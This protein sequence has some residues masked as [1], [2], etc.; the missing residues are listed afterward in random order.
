MKKVWFFLIAVTGLLLSVGLFGGQLSS[1]RP[2]IEPAPTAKKI[3]VI[4]TFYPL[5]E[6]TQQV[7]GDL[8]EVTNLTPAGVEPHDFEPSP[9]DIVALHQA[10][11]IIY[12]GAGFESWLEF[13][14]SD[15]PAARL[16]DTSESIALMG[17]DPHLWLD[18]A[19]AADQVKRITSALIELDPEHRSDYQSRAAAYLQQLTELDTLFQTTL[20]NCQTRKMVTSHN[21]FG[22]LARAYN[23]QVESIASF[24]PDE[25]PSAQELAALTEFVKKNQVKYVFSEILISPKLS[26]TLA[27]ETGAQIL[28]FNPLEGLT[29]AE[30]A[31]GKNYLSIQRENVAALKTA[32]QCQ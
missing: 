22:Y 21:S 2:V 24:S 6:F 25:E 12:N 13:L 9:Q 19:L 29:P 18:P 3:K 8:V 17:N 30:L 23:L 11:L 7:G 27:A 20:R 28:V 16:V 15:L 5:A 4:A 10:D 1:N 14:K 26:E 32:L 31:Q